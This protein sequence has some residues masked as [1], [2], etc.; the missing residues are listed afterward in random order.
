MVHGPIAYGRVRPNVIMS[1]LRVNSR[2]EAL[3]A[4]ARTAFDH[5]GVSERA[6]L[7]ALLESERQDSG[8]VASGV[9]ILGARLTV[10][11]G[12]FSMLARLDR[13]MDFGAD[14]Q[15]PV[16]LVY[17]LLSPARAKPDHLQALGRASR[18]LRDGGLCRQ[19]RH[20]PDA[21]AMATMVAEHSQLQPLSWA[22]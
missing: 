22:S 6:V 19:L 13:P 3:M 5:S 4:L 14:D 12:V 16:D 7:G 20:C 1:G 15:Q 9:A 10:F 17:L 18:L 11:G 21:A 8:A 2:M